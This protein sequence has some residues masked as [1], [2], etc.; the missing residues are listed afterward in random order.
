MI[1][2]G[3]V[4]AARPLT[5]DAVARAAAQLGC[6]VAAVRAVLVVE[7][8]GV[9][10]FLADVVFYVFTIFSYE[11]FTRWVVRRPD[12]TRAAMNSAAPAGAGP[13]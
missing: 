3:F 11:R 8:G 5:G 9:G 12:Y 2:P 10:G 6:Q 7:T 1:P 4:G 13:S